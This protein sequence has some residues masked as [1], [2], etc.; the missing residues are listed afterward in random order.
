[1]SDI[2]EGDHSFVHKNIVKT[3]Y[4]DIFFLAAI[5]TINKI[6]CISLAHYSKKNERK[7]LIVEEMEAAS[8]VGDL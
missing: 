1:L 3:Q 4:L 5:L 7:N 6:G 2:P 8:I